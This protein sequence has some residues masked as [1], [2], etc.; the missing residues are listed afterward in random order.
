MAQAVG[1]GR[2][3]DRHKRAVLGEKKRQLAAIVPS[4]G[5]DLVKHAGVNNAGQEIVQYHVLIVKS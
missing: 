5:L 4:V 1:C 3:L 2:K